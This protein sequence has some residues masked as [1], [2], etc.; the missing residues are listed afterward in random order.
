VSNPVTPPAKRGTVEDIYPLTP[1]QRGLLFHTL[2]APESG[3]YVEQLGFTIEGTFDVELFRRAWQT[4]LDR[5]AVLRT[6][7]V[8]EDLKE[9]LQLVRPRVDVPWISED[10][11]DVPSTEQ[12]VRL[13]ALA[14]DHRERPLILDRPPLMRMAVVRLSENTYKFFWTFHH[15]LL[16]GWSVSL[17]LREV[18]MF[19]DGLRKGHETPVPRPRPFRDLIAWFKKQDLSAAESFWS[20]RLKGFDAP[21][22]VGIDIRPVTAAQKR[23]FGT[24]RLEIS[25]AKTAEVQAFA[26]RQNLT[27]NT[28][29]QAAWAILLS[30]YGGTEDVV[31]GTTS[32]G[33]P[34][35]LPGAESMIGLFITM[36]PVRARVSGE[37]SVLSL[38]TDLQ[39]QQVE[40]R[41][42]EYAPLVDIHGWSDVP[43]ATPLFESAFVFENFPVQPF[44][45]AKGSGL[46][47]HADVP[48]SRANYPL[49]MVAAPGERLSLR[50]DYDAARFRSEAVKRM[51]S[52]FDKLL[53]QVVSNPVGRLD[54]MSLL[55]EPERVQL[56]SWND[57]AAAYSHTGPVHRLFEAQV[58]RTPDA[59]A[60]VSPAGQ[61]TYHALNVRANQ[62]A[63]HLMARGVKPEVR[64]ALC[65]SRS[66]DLLVGVLGILKAGGVYVPVDPEHPQDRLAFILA[67]CAA[68]VAVTE[69]ALVDRLPAHGGQ[70][71][72]LDAEQAAIAQQPGSDPE[73]PVLAEALSHVIYTSG[74]TGR[75]KGVAI[76]HESVSTL[77]QWSRTHFSDA[78]L[79]GVLAATS[80][81]FDLSVWEFF[82]PLS[83]GGTVVVAGNVLALPTLAAADRVT[84]INTV[85]S[86][87]AEL[88]RSG[89]IP[90]SV[91]TI[92]LAGEPLTTALADAIY[93][94]PTVQRVCDL[95][96]PSE[97][98]TYSTFA[99]RTRG[100]VATIGRPLANTQ[101]WVHSPES[102]LAPVG[103]PGELSLGGAGLARG[104]LARPDLTAERFV[105]NPYSSAPGQRLYRTGDRVRW[106][107]EGQLEFLG[108]IDH[109]VKIR[110]FR[111]ELGE[112]EAVLAHHASLKEAVVVAREDDAGDKRLVAYI[113]PHGAPPDV[114][115][116]RRHLRAA[117][118]EYMVP[119]AFV[120]LG[121]LPRTQSGK[122]D[123]R[124]LPDPTPETRSAAHTSP[125]SEIERQIAEMWQEVLGL[126]QVGVHENFFDLGGHSLQLVR[127]HTQLVKRLS[128]K[129]PLVA[130]FEYPT[131]AALA[132]HVA[133]DTVTTPTPEARQ[134]DKT[135]VDDPR[136]AI[137][138]LAGR[139]PG[140]RD[141]EEFW[142]QLRAGVEGIRTFSED[143]LRAAGI[144]EATLADPHYVRARGVLT[145]DEVAGFDAEMF[146]YPPREAA[147]IDPQHRVFL[148]CAWTALEKAGYGVR[149]PG[150]RV[151]VYAGA[152]ASIYGLGIGGF[153]GMLAR[154]SDFLPTR[155][156]YK[157]NLHGPSVNIQTACST[158]LVAVH[159]ACQSLRQRECEMAL[160]GGVSISPPIA[161]GYRYQEGGILSP[162]GH[163]RAFDANAAGTVE[164]MGVGIVVLKRYADAVRDGDPIHAVILGSAINNDGAQ[165]VGFTAPSVEGQAT[166]IADALAMGEVDP[167]T[168]SYIEAH[169]TGTALG[170]PI[171][172]SALA[173]VF[174][175][176]PRS[177]PCALGSVKA[178]IGHLDAAAGVTGLIKTVLALQHRELPPTLHYSA[179][180]PA[181]DFAASGFTVNAQLK[182][183]TVPEGMPRR[184]GVSSFGIGGTNAHVVLEEAPAVPRPG[185]ARAW[186]V[187]PVSARTASAM[188]AASEQ[189]AARISSE[190]SPTLADVAY[191][192]QVGRAAMTHRRA[193]VCREPADAAEALR[194]RRTQ[195][196]WTGVAPES[197][198][199]VV[200]V[201]PGQGAQTV[202][203][204]QSLY[205][206]EPVFRE[207]IDAC[208]V[209]LSSVLPIDLRE[210]LYPAEGA[211]EATTAR[212]TDTMYAQPAL[213]AVE[214][215]LARLWK[216][217]GITPVAC[218][219]HSVG[220]YAAACMAG[221]WTLEEAVALVARRGQLMGAT[222]RGAMLAVPLPVDLVSANLEHRLS[223]AAVNGP[224]L[225]VVSGPLEAIAAYETRLRDEG[226]EA[227]RLQTSH[228][229]HS[230]SMD[231]ALDAIAA[232]VSSVSRRSP[233][234][235]VVSNLT[236]TWATAEDLQSPT[237]WSR[238]VRES[239]QFGPG[240]E[241]LLTTYPDA[242]VL[243]VGPGQVLSRLVRRHPA[244]DAERLV[245]ASLPPAGS[246]AAV[247]AES[248]TLM[249]AA[250]RL[251]VA[252]ASIDWV[253][254]H[255]G[256]ERRRIP[257]P[258]YPFE[259][260]RYWIDIPR[261]A[262]ATKGSNDGRRNDLADWFYT[263][264]WNEVPLP[265]HSEPSAMGSAS[266]QWLVFLD[267]AGLGDRFVARIEAP[268][269]RI[270]TVVKRDAF[271][272][273]GPRRYAINPAAGRDYMSLVEALTS[274]GVTP[275]DVV[276]M[277]SVGPELQEMS[278]PKADHESGFL[279]VLRLTQALDEGGVRSPLR[280]TVVTSG[281]HDV[282]GEENLSPGRATVTGLCRV[283]PHEYPHIACSTIDVSAATSAG[284]VSERLANQLCRELSAEFRDAVV[285]LRGGHRWVR[286]YRQLRLPALDASA[287]IARLRDRGVYLIT[288]GL[289]EIGLSVAEWLVRRAAA[290]V[291]LVS[292][293]G[294]PPETT[295]DTYLREHDERDRVAR[296]I[297]RV[298]QMR[299]S[300]GE[301]FVVQANVTS[302]DDMT[303]A[304]EQVEA[305][306]GAVHG[307]VHA[308]GIVDA[309][310]FQAI[311]DT[312]DALCARHFEPKVEGLR[313]LDELL[314]NRRPDFCLVTSSISTTL[315]GWGFAAYAAA[316]AFMDAFA[317]SRSRD[318]AIPWICTNWDAWPARETDEVRHRTPTD[319]VMTR[320]EGVEAFGRILA[321]PDAVP[322]VIS[323]GDLDARVEQ[324]FS[325][326]TTEPI[327]QPQQ[328]ASHP[329][330][331]LETAYA[332]PQN[333]L[334]RSIAQV[335][336]ELLGTAQVGIHDSYY[337]LGGDSLLATQIVTRLRDRYG[338]AIS[339]R[340]FL[341]AGTVA[342]LARLLA[343][344]I[345]EE[346]AGAHE[347]REEIEID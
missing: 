239:V 316:N 48:S 129:V 92:N 137:I 235:P 20:N 4:V 288:G 143:E 159:A 157:L 198:R 33:R 26:R 140:A 224:R 308:A 334:E 18:E 1:L 109:Q 36:L 120:T 243:E 322:V 68:A 128:V 153:E 124:A 52:H 149:P 88:V 206:S 307:V 183:W 57:T 127:V 342:S 173:K 126:Q 267:E 292:R 311:V 200:F 152:S 147:Q 294:L 177:A 77:V 230:A 17:V 97:D 258:T 162:D 339:L 274:E 319:L 298:R 242:A 246:T 111:I 282:S 212:L 148:E 44:S 138:S 241:T 341:E 27:L 343:P 9:P 132:A 324:W 182:E 101:A 223:V 330:P 284:V 2:Y 244:C 61:L 93:A 270:T 248:S 257:L 136:V 281:V 329:R 123:R 269:D 161:R 312:D 112:I 178:N 39:R 185:S 102:A 302:R 297:K 247:E 175:R 300:G 340:Q 189:L 30:R 335:W 160:A 3:L 164:G 116:L 277:F 231:P 85:P 291:M 86:A 229:F 328:A 179:P 66:A 6:A 154:G 310:A 73:S 234:L 70:M 125:K 89:A 64:V 67:D 82:V 150:V 108:R 96:G 278:A 8:T 145:D 337:E 313:V 332:A 84:L 172:V 130:L 271:A 60:V 301:V 119:A 69:T 344:E 142:S 222:A 49:M 211:N 50:I 41:E 62:L 171:E 63:R 11:R 32:S 265:G 293:S 305:V 318:G 208:A 76:Q 163:C 190:S 203:M 323:T 176:S 12:D 87:M 338:L 98:T 227:Q 193:V 169:G 184:A 23:E 118:P 22:P 42:Y 279:S 113:V 289:G 331:N 56:E 345:V 104:Y 317:R 194:G 181:I 216:S 217:W 16:D 263:P 315:G 187:L 215:A 144:A 122:V 59:L 325:P 232:G 19:Y 287:P 79:S 264:V 40:Q 226:V 285:A 38:L 99:E 192:L 133:G 91:R 75:P 272:R 65:L 280:L 55:S 266:A 139:F 261:L 21:T 166:A 238:Q 296:R 115:D 209:Q 205:A 5:H 347:E 321:M 221:V 327:D 249:G 105:P 146:G 94:I 37:A 25:A 268:V 80:V 233:R 276:H 168:V 78:D 53:A 35:D 131:I 46:S 207:V 286:A 255:A 304:F 45:D 170:D 245:V 15:V 295:W 275:T 197:P 273:L 225:T 196:T 34:P 204:G 141:V 236:G 74:S 314:R 7:F 218:L 201:F 167:A 165:K 214:M 100:G 13:A 346:M 240:V 43:R 151:G 320:A 29:V 336:S 199:P 180:N 10:W 309:D 333:E 114:Q 134:R 81:C 306:W 303:K 188:A 117:V 219:G 47:V 202:G 283:I 256:E 213:F 253:G 106:L 110:G 155:V 107:S 237:Y 135:R 158:S 58:K 228:A 259:H 251:W 250:A 210:V 24:E 326:K 195:D 254:M 174:G 54:E 103:V 83:C 90:A 290:K 186:Q 262:L 260:Q 71:V 28:V 95:Y 191:T 299:A 252:G 220:E 72:C 156:S 31:Y 51:L 121:A 14:T